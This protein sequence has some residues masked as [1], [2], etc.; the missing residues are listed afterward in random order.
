MGK[1]VSLRSVDVAREREQAI[2]N[3]KMQSE[4]VIWDERGYTDVKF[5]S[6]PIIEVW[7]RERNK[8]TDVLA[9]DDNDPSSGVVCYEG[10]LHLHYVIKE[11]T[12]D[13]RCLSVYKEMKGRIAPGVLQ[14]KVMGYYRGDYKLYEQ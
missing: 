6:F 10:A 1:V 4:P 5:S 3:L 12:G 9:M 8:T 2:K 7:S 14:I 13:M 11:A